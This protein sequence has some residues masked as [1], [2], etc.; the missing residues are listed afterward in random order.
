MKI[1]I[2]GKSYIA[3]E[4]L[5][6]TIKKY[7][8]IDIC[9]VPN[10][11]DSR[12]N[13]WEPSLKKIAEKRGVEILDIQD[14]YE[15]ENLIFISLEF[16]RII[17]INKFN[18]ENLY[19]IHFSLLPAYKGVYTSALPILHSESRTG[20]TLHKIDEGI[21]TGPIIDQMNF[22]INAHE[23]ALSLYLKYNKYGLLLFKENI[24]RLI[25]G[26]FSLKKQSPLNASYYNRKSID[27]SCLS[28]NLNKT[29]FEINNQIRAFNFRAYQLPNVY[30]NRISHSKILGERSVEKSGTR[31]NSFEN[32]FTI[33][34]I[35]YNLKLY[36]DCLADAIEYAKTDDIQKLKKLA[37]DG[38]NLFEKFE[39]G[40]DLGIIAAYHG[41]WE[42]LKYVIDCGYNIFSKNVNGTNLLMYTI[43]SEK[44]EGME[45]M[46]IELL[47]RGINPSM[48][49]FGG[50]STIGWLNEY[51]RKDLI[52]LIENCK[53]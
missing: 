14:V 19:N 33:S 16:D 48:E 23:T 27:Y 9:V 5:L 31:V 2:A 44:E 53:K 21:D 13:R 6:Y 47:E 10:K 42:I 18:S 22:D 17:D 39:K 35:D 28:I 32:S 3:V 37:A 30:E 7:S 38:Y 45:Q 29:A 15:I 46:V 52:H 40:W 49:D 43:S 41:S 20:V 36:K 4:A 26:N 25:E 50:K 11:N 24:A 1:C 12:V 8:D 34:T 51:K